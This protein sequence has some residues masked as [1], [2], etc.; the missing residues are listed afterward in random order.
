MLL[1]VVEAGSII[2]GAG[3]QLSDDLQEMV[4]TLFIS[5]TRL[6]WNRN[7]PRTL[8]HFLKPAFS[9]VLVSGRDLGLPIP[10]S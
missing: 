7:A 8:G 5:S 4:T 1:R 2:K 10:T 3:I 9:G 6:N